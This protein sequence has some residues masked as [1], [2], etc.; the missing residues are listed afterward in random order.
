MRR[1]INITIAPAPTTKR[2]RKRT[3]RRMMWSMVAMRNREVAMLSGRV[4]FEC[5]ADNRPIDA[6]RMLA[7]WGL[8]SA[9]AQCCDGWGALT[10]SPCKPFLPFSP[11]REAPGKKQA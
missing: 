4:A 8:C 6:V 11:H 1:P 10:R 5:I 9:M 3:M 2:D 7:Q